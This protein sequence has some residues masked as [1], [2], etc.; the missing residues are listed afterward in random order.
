MATS[1]QPTAVALVCRDLH[2]VWAAFLRRVAADT[3]SFAVFVVMDV[4]SAPLHVPGDPLDPLTY[5]TEGD[6]A[7]RAAGYWGVNVDVIRKTPIAWDKA[8]HY[9]C[10]GPGRAYERVWFIEDDV[11]IPTVDTLARID[12]AHPHADI[13]SRNS[14]SGTD[15]GGWPWRL[16][17]GV[18]PQPWVTSM[19]CAVRL[20]RRVLNLVAAHARRHGRLHF[21]EPLFLTLATHAHFLC[22]PAEELDRILDPGRATPL[23]DMVPGA[24]YHPVKDTGAHDGMRAAIAAREET[25]P[26]PS[27][28][29]GTPPASVAYVAT[30]ASPQTPRTPPGGRPEP[31][32]ARATLLVRAVRSARRAVVC[33]WRQALK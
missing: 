30:S 8:L 2:P 9:F 32:G 5:V 3:P 6:A 33:A 23:A 13:V 21:L 28:P 7:C 12:A 4:A 22:E 20:S 29:P 1:N 25:V 16:I 24:M 19:V 10:T 15:A 11:F 27:T 31:I 14:E 17:A 18:L 26:S